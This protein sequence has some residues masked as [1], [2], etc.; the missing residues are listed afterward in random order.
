MTGNIKRALN[1]YLPHLIEAKDQNLN[2]ADTVLRIIKIFE[3]VFGYDAMKEIT[4][5][6]QIKDKF[7]DIAIKINNITKLLIEVKSAGMELRD[8]HIEQAMN[9]AANGNI[10]WVLLTNGLQWTLFHLSFGEGIEHERVFSVDLSKDNI[11]DAIK[12]LNLLTRE[13]VNADG[14][15]EYWDRHT[16]LSPESI[17]KALFSEE[18]LCEIRRIIR[19]REGFIID[20]EDL[21]STIHNMLS[22]ETRERVGPLHIYWKKKSKPATASCEEPKA[23]SGPPQVTPQPAECNDNQGQASNG[24]DKPPG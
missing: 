11:D 16:A 13:S 12:S 8:K 1:K 5:E 7:V 19:K 4:R 18:T 3:D 15:D 23:Q 17:G 6:Q 9:Y 14:L 10:K 2:E 24:N 22:T 20:V 21:G